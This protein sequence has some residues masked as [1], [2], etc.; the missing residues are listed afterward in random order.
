MRQFKSTGLVRSRLFPW[1]V[2]T[3]GNCRRD[4]FPL[5]SSQVISNCTGTKQK[6]GKR[7]HS[8]SHPAALPKP[9]W[10]IK[11]YNV[12]WKYISAVRLQM[13]QLDYPVLAFYDFRIKVLRIFFF[14]FHST[15]L[16]PSNKIGVLRARLSNEPLYRRKLWDRRELKLV[17]CLSQ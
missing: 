12:S 15:Y 8:R 13:V 5:Q 11:L 6:L 9:N 2:H 14:S 16:T 4:F 3:W 17:S 10:R 7:Y 1:R